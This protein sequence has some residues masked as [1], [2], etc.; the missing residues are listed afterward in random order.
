MNNS[1]S[2]ARNPADL[3]SHKWQLACFILGHLLIFGLVFQTV[4]HIQ[5][6]PVFL[7]FDYAS[8]VLQGNLP[9]RDFALEYPPLALI[10]F[11]LPRLFSSNWQVF[12]VLFQIEV[13]IF[14]L[15]GLFLIYRIS[16]LSGKA[17]WKMLAVYTLGILAIGPIIGQQYDIF[18][19]IVT[20]LAVY[21]FW[22]GKAAAAWSLLALGTMIKIYPAVIA[23]VFLAYYLRQRDWRKI[24]R[25]IIS[26]AAVNLIILA[27]FLILGPASL[28]TLFS[29][30]ARRGIQLE[31][32][33]SSFLVLASKLGLT[34]VSLEFSFG[35]WNLTG[36]AADILSKLSTAVLVILLLLEY[37][38]VYHKTDNRKMVF[39]CI[40]AYAFLAVAITLI[41]AKVLSPQ[42]LIW[43]IPFL[44][45]IGGG[46]RYT[47]WIIYF[48][49]GGLT[50][51][52]FPL[53][54]YDL[55]DL[56]TAAVAVLLARNVLLIM[57]A[58]LVFWSVIHPSPSNSS[59]TRGEESG[60]V[61][62]Y[63][64]SRSKESRNKDY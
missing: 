6:S 40:C 10:F 52:L 17:P 9:Y 21:F 11:I 12:A 37:W 60:E 16:R 49:I 38:L 19:A 44:P 53:S 62:I 58:L 54:Y 33:Y 45:A 3:A 13:I 51:Y 41:G 57:A 30:H 42:Y 63:S 47:I 59:P 36:N 7:Y 29:Y 56:K 23:P 14:D 1:E 25:G 55:M 31:S 61:D 15:A 5:Y 64:P 50:Y 20:L 28:L 24:W 18:P 48:V 39:S 2:A 8:K 46:Y 43:L 22:R 27:P 34:T 32:V 26:F 4:Y 35:S